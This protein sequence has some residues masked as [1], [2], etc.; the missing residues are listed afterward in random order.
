MFAQWRAHSLV[1]RVVSNIAGTCD[2]RVAASQ[3][4]IVWFCVVSMSGLFGLQARRLGP[5]Q[6]NGASLAVLPS[7]GNVLAYTRSVYRMLCRMSEV[8]ISCHRDER[9][10]ATQQDM[11]RLTRQGWQGK[12][13]K[14]PYFRSEEQGAT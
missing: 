4:D 1:W 7:L 2:L 9:D 13:Q 5:V 12:H 10:C 11:G 14:D 6:V 8:Y 3:R